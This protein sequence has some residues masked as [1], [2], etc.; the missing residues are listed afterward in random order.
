MDLATLVEMAEKNQ[1]SYEQAIEIFQEKY[2]EKEISA[3]YFDWR[4]PDYV[5]K[6]VIEELDRVR[7]VNYGFLLK[8]LKYFGHSMMKLFISFAYISN[9]TEL[10]ASIRENCAKSLFELT[11]VECKG[12][13]LAEID[14][15]F[16]NVEFLSIHGHYP[17]KTLNSK[18]LNFTEI[19]PQLRR[20]TFSAKVQVND[21]SVVQVYSNLAHFQL[22]SRDER[23]NMNLFKQEQIDQVLR[24]NTYIRTLSL[25]GIKRS[26]LK[27]VN[28]YLPRLDDFEIEYFDNGHY[29]ASHEIVTFAN[30]R[31]LK[32]KSWHQISLENALFTKLEELTIDLRPEA[33]INWNEWFRQHSNVTKLMVKKSLHSDNSMEFSRFAEIWP[34][35]TEVAVA[36][37]SVKQGEI[38]EF[39]LNS[40]Q[41]KTLTLTRIN[42]QKIEYVRDHLDAYWNIEVIDNTKLYSG[43]KLWRK[44]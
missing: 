16:Q 7:V 14:A 39:V 22:N 29:E 38:L 31:S 25:T 13:E 15:P 26:L 18:S 1:N 37:E 30:I 4:I 33:L 36:C 19:F 5:G 10:M 11:L 35:L 44:A 6:L 8:I 41:L 24:L 3:V 28:E 2:A 42:D 9:S 32:I 12:T 43:I 21:E 27:T 23:T 40:K 17:F 20:L 34:K